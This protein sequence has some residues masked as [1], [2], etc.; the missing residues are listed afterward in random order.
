[1]NSAYI[2]IPNVA[3]KQVSSLKMII[4]WYISE[5]KADIKLCASS[6]SAVTALP[7]LFAEQVHN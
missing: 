5:M 2:R 4:K 3:R 1:M 7:R 6:L